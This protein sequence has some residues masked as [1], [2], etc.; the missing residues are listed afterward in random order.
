M[1][2]HSST[3]RCPARALGSVMRGLAALVL[4][5]AGM[6]VPVLAQS[7]AEPADP[8]DNR[9][10]L[11]CHDSHAPELKVPAAD[12]EERSLRAVAGDAFGQGVHAT[13]TCV[14]CHTGV[15]TV[16]KTGA[17]HAA[18]N[19]A[20][21]ASM[22][23]ASC[24]QKL[25]DSARQDNTAASKPRLGVVV[26]NITAYQQS[27]HARPGKEDPSRPLASC[28]GCHD[29][30]SFNIP[31]KASPAFA[32]WRLNVPSMCGESCHTDAL[33]AYTESVHGQKSVVEH[34]AKAAVCSDCH[35]AHD[36]GNT[37]ADPVK[38]AITANC[39]SCHEDKYASYKSTYHGKVSTLG[40]AYTAKCFDCHG[41]HEILSADNPDSMVH[42]DNRM[43]TCQTC[44][45]GKKELA[46]APVGY[47]SFEPH[48][49]T[50]DFARYP[51]T[52]IAW[53]MMVGLLVGTFGFFWLHTALWF[54]RELQDRR[55]G[56]VSTR[57][58]VSAIPPAAKG[59]HIQRFGAVWRAGHLL[60][61]VSLML[62]TLTG[63]PLFYPDSA[64]APVVM[65]ALGGPQ[66]SGLIHRVC[67]IVFAGVFFWHLFYIALRIWRQRATFRWFGPDSLIP[68]WQDLLGMIAMFK[69]FFGKGPRPVFDRWTYWEKFDYWAPFWG[70]TIIGV[71]G[72]VMWLPELFGAFLPGWVFNV[73][74]I[75]HGEEAF[76]AVVFLFTVHFFNNHFRPDKFPIEV[77]M[78]TGTMSLEH[79]RKEHALEYQR[80]VDSGQ[81]D[82][83]LVDAPSPAMTLGSKVLGFTLI[84]AGLVLLGGVAVG[85]F[86]G[87]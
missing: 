69:W 4:V 39:G 41:S 87:N 54:Y 24:H 83:V 28:D 77:V 55:Q 36:I 63:M 60:F 30:H 81:L 74:A 65:Q 70:V 18:E 25:W 33:E 49:T 47:A 12:G 71:S 37:S 50:N 73:A 15:T 13:M 80:L 26:E 72:L 22:D 9:S 56:V 85:F 17:G 78:F 34:D 52:W 40:Y 42:A 58:K 20:V 64:W 82:S 61:A 38:L 23:C 2:P 1:P 44:H 10:C 27:F 16:P 8:A 46:L 48:A 35:S 53:Q 84:A 31:P 75:F 5:A 3:T 19:P 6:G 32:E 43:D 79:F 7:S 59:R 14:A 62:L 86:G 66:V 57:V 68:N 29:T 67:A 11:S 45:S 76:L 21:L 51:Q